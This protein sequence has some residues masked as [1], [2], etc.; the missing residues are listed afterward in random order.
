LPKSPPSVVQRWALS[1]IFLIMLV[2]ALRLGSTL[3][4]PIAVS[5]LFALLLAKPVRW[6]SRHRIP[7]SLGAGIVVLGVVVTALGV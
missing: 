6:M 7:V 5:G 2:A 1:G 3:L 4:M